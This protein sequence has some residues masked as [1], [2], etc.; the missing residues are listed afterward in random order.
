MKI[1]E[2]KAAAE[3]KSAALNQLIDDAYKAGFSAAMLECGA[4]KIDVDGVTYY[5]L[6]LP[7][8]TLWSAP[9][10]DQKRLPVRLCHVEAKH[11]NLPTPDQC[12]ELSGK[13]WFLER[14]TY[15]EIVGPNGNRCRV[16]KMKAEGCVENNLHFWLNA[17]PGK[18][19]SSA[20]IS[21]YWRTNDVDCCTSCLFTGFRLPVILVKNKADL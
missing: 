3:E 13:C 7:S 6:G 9:L 1:E 12:R 20:T 21:F 17:D 8:G 16:E 15:I 5:D 11:L 18:S 10:R 2:I 19:T 14:D 4:K